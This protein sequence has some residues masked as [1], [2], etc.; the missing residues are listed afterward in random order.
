M[1]AVIQHLDL[2]AER[3]LQ[4]PLHRV[5]RSVSGTLHAS[6]TAVI[7]K[8]KICHRHK[9]AALELLVDNLALPEVNRLLAVHIVFLEL[10]HDLLRCY[11]AL[12]LCIGLDDIRKL[13]VHSLR[14]LESVIGIHDKGDA[15]LAG[16][17]VDAHHRLVLA[18]DVCRIDGQ[19]GHFPDAVIALGQRCGSLA[20]GV[21]MGSG[22][23]G[24][25]QFSRIGLPV[26]HRHLGA[27]LAHLHDVIDIANLQLRVDTLGEHIIGQI[28]N[29]HVARS[30]TVSEKGSF[31]ALRAGQHGKLRGCNAGTPVIVGMDAED[32][33]L[34][35]LEVA[36][37]P[38]N[39][40]C[41]D[42][43]RR[44]LHRCRQVDDDLILRSGTPLL[45]NRLADLQRIVQL[46]AGKAF[47]RILQNHLAVII[48]HVFLHHAH[49]V[50]GDLLYFLL[51]RVEHYFSLQGG[52]GIINMHNCLRNSLNGFKSTLNQMLA[53]LGQHL[54]RNIGGN[55]LPVYQNAE[56]VKFNLGSCRETDLD[57]LKAHLHQH[58]EHL[59]LFFHHHRLH[60]SLVAVPQVHAAPDR[61][62]P[63][64]AV[65]PLA[66]RIIHHRHSLVLSEV[67]HVSLSSCIEI[68]KPLQPSGCRGE[69]LSAVPLCLLTSSATHFRRGPMP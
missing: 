36:V 39:L 29:V 32:D 61:G 66:L 38:L 35:V 51:A 3:L 23:G 55:H 45:L 31:H 10:G 44:H 13:L 11:L 19:I 60:Q 50:D 64:L 9:C 57:L 24:K 33:A 30:L 21:L 14:K 42:V 56:E 5:D 2:D 68:E 20:D 49:A 41:I 34:S 40:V 26:I 1:L 15:A 47:R 4:R 52:C 6:L 27:P 8:D 43:R 63:N 25:D 53:A 28:Q 54:Y 65:R 58:I 48:R 46:C 16:L 22:E 17:A 67:H 12:T 59:Y 37:H 62:L 7:R 69:K 18:A